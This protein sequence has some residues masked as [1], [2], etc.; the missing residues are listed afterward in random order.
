[1]EEHG[2]AVGKGRGTVGKTPVF[3]VAQRGSNGSHGQ[4]RASVLP[5]TKGDALLG[6]VK[7]KVLPAS[8]VYT[9]EA[10]AYTNLPKMGYQHSRVNHRQR[11]YVS[12]DV[13]TNSVEG[14][15]SLVKRGI[16][17]VYHGVSTQHLQSYLDEYAFRYNNRDASGRGMF[18]AFLSRIQKSDPTLS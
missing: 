8:I 9:D 7:A 11:I 6:A 16:A 3:G 5:N 15:W 18:D 13:H 1:M 14:F 10:T 2:S 4:I 12:G 17:G